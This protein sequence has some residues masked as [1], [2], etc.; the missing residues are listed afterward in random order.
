MI[1]AG[2]FKVEN[3]GTEVQECRD[4]FELRETQ[5]E[6]HS[7]FMECLT[8][9]MVKAPDEEYKKLMLDVGINEGALALMKEAVEH[10]TW[11]GKPL[12]VAAVEE[13]EAPPEE[14]PVTEP[15]EEEPAE[16]F[17]FTDA[18]KSVCEN[19][20]KQLKCIDALEKVAEAAMAEHNDSEKVLQNYIHES[21]DYKED[22]VY[23]AAGISKAEYDI[24]ADAQKGGGGAQYAD[25]VFEARLGAGYHWGTWASRANINDSVMDSSEA[26]DPTHPNGFAAK[27]E[28]IWWII[29]TFNS[30]ESING[31]SL[32]VG[33]EG[34]V[35][36]G[37]VYEN[38][39]YS[40]QNKPHGGFGLNV[41][42]S[43][44]PL[45]HLVLGASAGWG[46]QFGTTT[47]G[48]QGKNKVK[49]NLFQPAFTL[50]VPFM[51]NVAIYAQLAGRFGRSKT[52]HLDKAIADGEDST[53]DVK[54]GIATFGVSVAFG[55]K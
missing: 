5:C 4:A 30:G 45:D 36:D 31:F 22:G 46:M 11:N 52:M 32:G 43:Y 26:Q 49:V 55:G 40:Y 29:P 28:A 19:A 21:Q 47:L 7:A 1:S 39:A 15:G 8:D 33:A 14:E 48:P 12:A 51:E 25:N 3:C 16:E 10:G 38:N 6:Q 17:D 35:G 50:S 20:K 53:V 44:Q 2:N 54:E 23:E 27:L 42:L 24:I 37:G 13:T 34:S 18:I 41:H 9:D